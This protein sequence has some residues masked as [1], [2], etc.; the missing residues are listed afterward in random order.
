MSYS[1]SQ[2]SLE[3]GDL[4]RRMVFLL[5]K[6]TPDEGYN[7]SAIPGVRFLRSNRPLKTTPVLYDPGIVIVCQGR[8]RG[9]FGNQ[10]Y[11]YDEQQ[12]LAVSVPLPFEMET[13]ASEERPPQES[14]IYVS[15]H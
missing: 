5:D 9:F 12:Y 3:R 13:D 10:V 8:K 15:S 6:L 14:S 7:L 11:V 1:V 2:R 4:R